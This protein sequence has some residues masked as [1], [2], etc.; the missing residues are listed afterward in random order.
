MKALLQQ[1]DLTPDQQAKADAI[2]A[3]AR[4][5]AQAAGD[6][7]AKRQIFMASQ[8]QIQA[9]LTPEQKTKLQQ[10]RAAQKAQQQGAAQGQQP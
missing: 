5:Q 2:M 4:Q 3:Q 6:P 1:L 9:I 8:Q 10:L 7:D